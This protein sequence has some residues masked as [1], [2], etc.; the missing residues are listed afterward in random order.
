MIK[1]VIIGAGHVATHLCHA[2]LNTK[3]VQ[4]VQ[5][6]NRSATGLYTKLNIPFTTQLEALVEANCYIMAVHDD[7]IAPLSARLPFHNRLVVHTSGSAPLHQLSDQQKRGVFYPLQSFSKEGTIA[8]NT[9]PVCLEVEH[10]ENLE[11]L[12]QLASSLTQKQYLISSSQRNALHVAAVF[13]NNF[14]NHMYAEAK[15]ICDANH[16]PFEL[17]Y[18]LI[19]ETANKLKIM[20]PRAAQ[21]GPAIRNDQNTIAR[22]LDTLTT[23]DQKILYKTLTTV[24]QQHHYGK[25]L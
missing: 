12:Q 13:A 2:F 15:K 7:A 14:S 4:L 9:I 3:D 11:L 17:L 16:I 18:P 1:V 6:Y 23:R 5:G 19:L 24:I 10:Q 20:D 8:F 25:K 22:H 21:T